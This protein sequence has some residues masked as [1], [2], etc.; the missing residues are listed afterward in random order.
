MQLIQKHHTI[1]ICK[2][3]SWCYQITE[4]PICSCIPMDE[5]YYNCSFHARKSTPAWVLELCVLVIDSSDDE[6][7]Y[8]QA[9]AHRSVNDACVVTL[10]CHLSPWQDKPPCRAGTRDCSVLCSR[11]TKKPQLFHFVASHKAMNSIWIWKIVSY[12]GGNA[13]QE[14][15]DYLLKQKE[16]V[17]DKMEK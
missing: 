6:C 7:W 15:H 1:G 5:Q 3:C 13:V 12:W 10:N 11:N 14:L 4:L 9:G 16:P 8:S 17:N 2:D